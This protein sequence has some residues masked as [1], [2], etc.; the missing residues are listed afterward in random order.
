MWK[1]NAVALAVLAGCGSDDVSDVDRLMGAWIATGNSASCAVAAV[2]G[3]ERDNQV[4]LDIICELEDGT[5]GLD[6][7]LADFT[8]ADG[9]L[10]LQTTHTTCPGDVLEGPW[11]MGYEFVGDGLRLSS[12]SGLIVLE[13]LDQSMPGTGAAQFGC[14]T[15]DGFVPYPVTRL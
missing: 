12:P 2:F 3:S 1:V 7:E 5:I 8:A 9:V 14:F 15:D 4:E 10:E 13:R 11:T 6:A